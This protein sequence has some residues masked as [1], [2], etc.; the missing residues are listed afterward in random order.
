MSV[1]Q[2][3]LCCECGTVE[4]VSVQ[5]VTLCCECVCVCVFGGVCRHCVVVSIGN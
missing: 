5:Q 2:V 1:Q 4:G 3:A